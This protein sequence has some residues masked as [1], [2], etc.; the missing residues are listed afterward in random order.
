MTATPSPVRKFAGWLEQQCQF[1]RHLEAEAG[2][3][4]TANQGE[5]YRQLMQQKALFL[6]ALA[7]EAGDLLQALPEARRRE[8]EERLQ[9]F[10]RGA[11]TALCKNYKRKI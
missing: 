10:R 8:S 5:R 1:L 9:G 2:K 3:A 6:R 4:L 7:D 11:D